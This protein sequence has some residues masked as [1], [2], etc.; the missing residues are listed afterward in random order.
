MTAAMIR[1]QVAA[2]ASSPASASGFDTNIGFH[3]ASDDLADKRLV[4]INEILPG[5]GLSV[6][7]AR[8]AHIPFLPIL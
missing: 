3:A 1:R 2:P 5:F 4:S 8:N 6:V 7:A